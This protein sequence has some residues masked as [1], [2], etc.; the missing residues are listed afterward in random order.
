MGTLFNVLKP[1]YKVGDRV[2]FARRTQTSLIGMEIEDIK[3]TIDGPRY[4]ISGAWW[5]EENLMPFDDWLKGK[6]PEWM[7]LMK[8]K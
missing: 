5:V 1:K 6:I 7:G 3:G 2:M 8:I 4:L